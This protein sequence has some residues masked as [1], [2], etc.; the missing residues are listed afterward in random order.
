[1]L[2]KYFIEYKPKKWLF[3]GVNREIYSKK[4][5]QMILKKLVEKVRIKKHVTVHTLRH[6]FATHL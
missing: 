1:M 5:I 6:F 3:E 4:S 2:R